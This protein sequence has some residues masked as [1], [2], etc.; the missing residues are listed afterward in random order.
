MGS[1]RLG[2]TRKGLTKRGELKKMDRNE[3]VLMSVVITTVFFGSLFVGYD[4]GVDTC[5][6]CKCGD[7]SAE[8]E[9]CECPPQNVTIINH[10][11]AVSE[12]NLSEG[13]RKK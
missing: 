4:A 1:K 12:L 10:N 11:C 9:R 13:E 2:R 5:P 8:F 3:I 7:C 6:D